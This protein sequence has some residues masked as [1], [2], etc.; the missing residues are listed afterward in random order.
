MNA[1]RLKLGLWRTALAII[2]TLVVTL[3]AHAVQHLVTPGDDWQRLDSRLRPGDEIVLMPGRHRCATFEAIVGTSKFPIIIRGADPQDPPL[4]EGTREGIRIKMAAHIVIKNIKITGGTICGISIKN[5]TPLQQQQLLRT[6]KSFS[7]TNIRIENVEIS[8]IGPRGLRHAI[9]AAGISALRIL[10]SQITGWG[11]SAVELVA[12]DDVTISRCNFASLPD[13]SQQFGVRIRG[14]TQRVQ[15][16]F[17]K[18]ENAG[19]RVISIGGASEPDEFTNSAAVDPKSEPVEASNVRVEHCIINGGGCGIA[20]VHADDCVVRN[21]TIIRPK[22]TIMAMLT[23]QKDERFSTGKRNIFGMNIVTWQPGD[24]KQL[25]SISTKV[26]TE[27][28]VLEE[29][30]WWSGQ[31]PEQ[32]K[33]LGDFP[34]KQ[35]APQITDMDPKLNQEHKPTDPALKNFGA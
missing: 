15:V 28:F 17:C 8:K 22:L 6:G 21:N 33:K 7:A 16:E 2:A 5:G 24:F 30:V 12:C 3:P 1:A 23:E 29:N 9:V 18:F 13:Y 31:T 25:T 32:L 27:L 19:E 4:I 14:G 10:D 11:G 20:F 35:Q 26:N 34:G